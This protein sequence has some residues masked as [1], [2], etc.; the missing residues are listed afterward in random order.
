[1]ASTPAGITS[2]GEV[3]L[4]QPWHNRSTCAEVPADQGFQAVIEGGTDGTVY[5]LQYNAT[6]SDGNV[7]PVNQRINCTKT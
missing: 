5:D 1:M 4:N 3:V 6:L 2:A 7:R